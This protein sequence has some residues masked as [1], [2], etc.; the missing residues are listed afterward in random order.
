MTDDAN[1]IKHEGV[2]L[3]RNTVVGIVDANHELI[4]V[5]TICIDWKKREDEHHTRNAELSDALA[6]LHSEAQE[7]YK[8]MPL[9]N[10]FKVAIELAGFALRGEEL[11]AG[12]QEVKTLVEAEAED[13]MPDAYYEG[14]NNEKL[15]QH[16]NEMPSCNYLHGTGAYAAYSEGV[17]AYRDELAAKE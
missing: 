9:N 3:F 2:T 5:G 10:T 13:K 12:P 6:M 14:Y 4:T 11:P 16:T 15:L 7:V 17:Q 8:T 1:V